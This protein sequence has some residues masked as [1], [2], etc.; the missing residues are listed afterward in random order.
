MLQLRLT[1][2]HVDSFITVYKTAQLLSQIPCLEI[3]YYALESFR[4]ISHN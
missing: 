3:K 1:F 2:V 4:M